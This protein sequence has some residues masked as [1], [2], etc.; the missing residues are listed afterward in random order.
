MTLRNT[1]TSYGSVTKTLHW[2][3]FILVTLLLLVGFFMDDIGDKQL[4][5]IVYNVHK[6]TGLVVL[7]TMV[8]F[9]LWSAINPKPLYPAQMPLWEK[10]LARAVHFLLY[11]LLIL[12]PLSGWIFTTAAGKPP[13]FFDFN[14][15]MPEIPLSK[16]LAKAVD[17][18]HV[19]I[20]WIILSLLVLHLLGALK[21]H[22]IDKNNILRRMMGR[23]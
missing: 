19:T 6:L 4:S 18:M 9:L 2:I 7:C 10:K 1:P 11:L 14:I 8:I 20:A 3:V 5:K 15:A 17:E 23:G 22:F 12:M 13:H 16:P 21:H